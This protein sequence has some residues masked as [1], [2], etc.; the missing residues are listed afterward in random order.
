MPVTRRKDTGKWVY[1]TASSRVTCS[2]SACKRSS[3]PESSSS[4]T[5]SSDST[6]TEARVRLLRGS[7]LVQVWH[8]QP[9]TGTPYDV[10]VPKKR[11]RIFATK[12]IA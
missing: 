5:P 11:T 3:G 4:L 2:L 7:S 1:R 12:T 10:E 9:M 6:Y 8:G